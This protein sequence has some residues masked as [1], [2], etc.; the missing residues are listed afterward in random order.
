MHRAESNGV[1]TLTFIH[2]LSTVLV[3]LIIRSK[4]L[5]I[6]LQQPSTFDKESSSCPMIVKSP[7]PCRTLVF[8]CPPCT[9]FLC[10]VTQLLTSL[11]VQNLIQNKCSS[12]KLCACL[13][14]SKDC[15]HQ[16]SYFIKITCTRSTQWKLVSNTL[17]IDV[18]ICLRNGN[19]FLTPL[20][21]LHW[22][23]QE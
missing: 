13:I 14:S 10:Q 5:Q 2:G 21:I 12:C 7:C 16:I 3:P 23:L 11:H 9:L 22:E 8:P 6:V 18:G 4:V 20:V 15:M 17:D 1:Y 19:Q